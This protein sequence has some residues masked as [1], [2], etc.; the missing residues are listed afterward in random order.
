M[1]RIAILGWGSL[2]WCPR[3]LQYEGEWQQ[4]GPVL[5]IEFSRI[6]SD[7]RLTLVIDTQRG[8]DTPTRFVASSHTDLK[9]A[10]ENLRDRECTLERNIGYIDVVNGQQRCRNGERVCQAIRDWAAELGFDAVIWTDLLPK[11][12]E[13]KPFTVENA[14][15]YLQSLSPAKAACAREYIRNAPQEVDTPLRRRLDEVGWLDE[16]ETQ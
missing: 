11:F 16:E 3:Q 6:S 9:S 13:G 1:A 8:V 14:V 2:I 15:A 12:E 5:P 7:G 10:I 4:D